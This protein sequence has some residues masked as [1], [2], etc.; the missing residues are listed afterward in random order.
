MDRERGQRGNCHEKG[1]RN[2]DDEREHA[3]RQSRRNR[4]LTERRRRANNSRFL[5]RIILKLG[6]ASRYLAASAPLS[7]LIQANVY[8]AGGYP[9]HHDI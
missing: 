8:T 1:P 7:F 9:N 2:D 4:E 5:F 6:Q 3:E